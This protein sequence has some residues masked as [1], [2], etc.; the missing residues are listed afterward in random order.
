MSINNF[1]LKNYLSILEPI[2]L[3]SLRSKIKCPEASGRD[4][5]AFG[6]ELCAAKK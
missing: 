3:R 6:N 4:K 5:M 2:S 1:L